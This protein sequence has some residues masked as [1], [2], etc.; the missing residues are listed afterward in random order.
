[1]KPETFNSIQE[2]S[3]Y[4]CVCLGKSK[5][6]LLGSSK[7]EIVVLLQILMRPIP[8]QRQPGYKYLYVKIH[9]FQL[10]V[11]NIWH[12]RLDKN[13]KLTL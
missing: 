1:M 11:Y 8:E 12:E 9:G 6:V 4:A 7:S 2:C 13:Y 3:S 10:L 5:D